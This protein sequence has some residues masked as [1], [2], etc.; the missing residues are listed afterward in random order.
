MK[1]LFDPKVIQDW[2]LIRDIIRPAYMVLGD[3]ELDCIDV[4]LVDKNDYGA[5]RSEDE[6]GVVTGDNSFKIMLP[7]NCCNDEEVMAFYSTL[8]HELGHGSST[9]REIIENDKRAVHGDIDVERLEEIKQDVISGMEEMYPKAGN[10]LRALSLYV[11]AVEEAK[12]EAFKWALC[13]KLSSENKR[14]LEHLMAF[15]QEL[16]FWDLEHAEIKGSYALWSIMKYSDFSPEATYDILKSASLSDLYR[17]IASNYP[18]I[19]IPPKDEFYY[20]PLLDRLPNGEFFKRL[21]DKDTLATE[22]T[23]E[24]NTELKYETIRKVIYELI[25]KRVLEPLRD[26][27]L[28]I[29]SVPGLKDILQYQ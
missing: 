18:V 20:G 11:H 17:C 13:K 12:A 9:N 29:D 7:E 1:R 28:D 27:N 19:K 24:M 2:A 10:K 4:R 15:E 23:A 22:E 6:G 25:E 8:F 26:V 14:G 21:I 3:T 16:C 5:V